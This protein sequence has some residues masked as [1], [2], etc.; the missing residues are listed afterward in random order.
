MDDV[1]NKF[2]DNCDGKAKEKAKFS[3]EELVKALSQAEIKTKPKHDGGPA[4]ARPMFK[5][6][7]EY[8]ASQTGM[9][10]RDYFA[11]NIDIKAEFPSQQDMEDFMGEEV[12]ENRVEQ[13]EYS[14]KTI[15]KL[16][17]MLADAMLAE[18]D[19]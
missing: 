11:A 18:R 13:I 16:R 3:K 10:L 4:F 14:L 5:R 12:P 17:Y 15:A 7:L 1:D 19:K 9:S 8:S 2:P 6:G